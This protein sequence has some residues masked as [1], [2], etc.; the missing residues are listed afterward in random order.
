MIKNIKFS[1]V[2]IIGLVCSSSCTK[3]LDTKP[4]DGKTRQ[5]YWQ[6]ADQLR[7]A[8]VGCYVSLASPTLVQNMFIW[9]ELRTDMI[10]LT[11]ASTTEESQYASAN[12][13]STSSLTKWDAVYAV[14]NNCN[15]VI[16]FGPS[17][18]QND[19]TLTQTQLNAY[20]AEARGL[21]ALMYFYLV[22]TFG[23]VPLQLTASSTDSTIQLLAKSSQQDVLK[24]IVDDLTFAE[25]NAV[26]SFGADARLNKGRLTK[27]GINAIQADVYLWMAD[28]THPEYYANCIT[29]CDK[30][31]NSGTLGLMDGSSQVDWYTNVFY[32]G[33]SNESIF[34][35]QFDAQLLSPF[36]TLF[37][38]PSKKQFLAAPTLMDQLFT[39]DPVD[40]I[41]NKDIRGD[42]G[43]LRATDNVIWKFIG[44]PNIN[45]LRTVTTAYT[46]WFLYR[47]SDILL[48]KAEACAWTPG[49]GQTA[50]DLIN[51]VRT[52]AHA[53][54]G[55]AQS[56]SITDS[57]AITEYV[58]AE[59]QREFAFEGKRWFDV[60]RCAKRDNYTYINL[61]YP[62]VGTNAGSTKALLI[63]SKYSDIRSHYLPINISELTA[64]K[65]L[66]QN[67]FYQ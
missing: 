13:L 31:I 4:I 12:I 7:A 60:L 14:I 33:N 28:S 42:A 17:V 56:P 55:S 38:D 45:T 35:I 48:L 53:L 47:Y 50:L 63:Q 62:V 64:D 51:A 34:E 29:A 16:Q 24:V 52:R 3:W 20:L 22:R 11:P 23:D 1:A 19:P 58:L 27:Y 26:F 43:S 25:Q 2:L 21:R 67:T 36:F 32:N 49:K 18:M 61:I 9:G 59:R 5:D 30:V 37:G 8:V 46:H 15:T 40:P 54:S 57:E 6:T 10:S 66:V 65:N 44:T 41:N 39:V